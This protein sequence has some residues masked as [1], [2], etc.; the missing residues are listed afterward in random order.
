M[1]SPPIRAVLFDKDGTLLDFVRTWEPINR[2]AALFA[3]RGDTALADRLLHL[4]GQD[5][6]TG[7]MRPGSPLAAGTHDEVAGLFADHLGAATPPDLAEAIATIF[8]EGGARHAV[9]ARGAEETVALLAARGFAM[10]VA[11]NDTL[12]G[13]EASL[14]RFPGVLG[15]FPFRAGCDSGHGAK[16]EAGMV[17][18]FAEAV[19]VAPQSIAVVGDSLHDLEMAR[20]AN[21]GLRVG[22]LGGTSGAGLLAPH[23]D[24]VIEWLAELPALLAGP[25]AGRLI[26]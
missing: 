7:V 1:P 2:E 16:P 14:G 20:R 11:T 6:V 13:L 24:H 26:P 8:A 10:G 22:V 5:P 4:G 12:A 15:H 18:A 17:L 25:N 23:A 19:G 3:A 21:A 9:L